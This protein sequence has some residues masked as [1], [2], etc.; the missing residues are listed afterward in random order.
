MPCTVRA[1]P[2][3]FLFFSF[4]LSLSLSRFINKQNDLWSQLRRCKYE[5]MLANEE[6]CY[7]MLPQN[8]LNMSTQ[9]LNNVDK[10]LHRLW[11]QME[12]D[13]PKL[14]VVP[15][16]ID[17]SNR[18]GSNNSNNSN[19]SSNSSNSGWGMSTLLSLLPLSATASPSSS[20]SLSSLG[21]SM[22]TPS[23]IRMYA[24]L[25]EYL[26]FF[27]CEIV[28]LRKKVNHYT[29]ALLKETWKKNEQFLEQYHDD[30]KG[31]GRRAVV[32]NEGGGG[33]TPGTGR[34]RQKGPPLT[35]SESSYVVGE[36]E[37][38]EDKEEVEKNAVDIK[39]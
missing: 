26:Y 24:M 39:A 13:L 4:F 14:G 3:T 17:M 32:E 29:E 34:R 27:S 2:L 12:Q 1:R 33:G 23:N 7:G 9:R 16:R 10:S 30:G 15:Q 21:A 36:E 38:E 31:G 18:K 25:V 5:T 22:D 8:V 6:E 37:E 20:A 19:C 28:R 35:T 11:L